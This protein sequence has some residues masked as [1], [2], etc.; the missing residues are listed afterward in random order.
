MDTDFDEFVRGRA[1]DL[2]RLAFLPGLPGGV[3]TQ[4]SSTDVVTISGD[5]R[6]LGGQVVDASGEIQ[7]VRWTCRS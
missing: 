5:G 4:P 2:L 6:V 7:A 1:D 3:D